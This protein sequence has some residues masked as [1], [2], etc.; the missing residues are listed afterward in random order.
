MWVGGRVDGWTD[1]QTDVTKL[2]V[3]FRIFANAPNDELGRM[4]KEAVVIR[5]EVILLFRHSHRTIEGNHEKNSCH[6]SRSQPKF[7]PMNFRVRTRRDK[8]SLGYSV[9]IV[10][11]LV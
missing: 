8:I 2:I 4:C 7:E 3:A 11:I 10:H 6:D 5:F 9:H 1:R